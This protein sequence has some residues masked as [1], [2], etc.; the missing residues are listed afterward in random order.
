MY[1]IHN[2]IKYLATV[3]QKS[4]VDGDLQHGLNT[5]P[6][7]RQLLPPSCLN[8]IARETTLPIVMW[9]GK[10]AETKAKQSFVHLSEAIAELCCLFIQFIWN[11]TLKLLKST[12]FKKHIQEYSREQK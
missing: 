6:L 5:V 12:W 10:H 1:L 3:S 8:L 11:L 4:K 9:T 7:K 2:C